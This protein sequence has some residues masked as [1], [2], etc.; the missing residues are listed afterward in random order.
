MYFFG[1][2]LVSCLVIAQGIISKGSMIFPKPLQRR[3]VSLT[4]YQTTG[5]SNVC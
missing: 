5:N 4:V 3:Y 1:L 2:H